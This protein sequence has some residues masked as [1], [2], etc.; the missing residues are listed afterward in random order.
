MG[1]KSVSTGRTTSWVLWAFAGMAFSGCSGAEF[2]AAAYGGP[3]FPSDEAISI[4]VQGGGTSTA[5]ADFSGDGTAG[6]RFGGY[7]DVGWPVDVGVGVDASYIGA[8]VDD[9]TDLDTAA[10][11]FLAMARVPF[12]FVSPYVAIGPSI[13]IATA[14]FENPLFDARD[15][16][17]AAA[18]DFRIGVE[19]KRFRRG[20]YSIGL[21]S[22]Y[23]LTNALPEFEIPGGLSIEV[24]SLT[25]HIL[26]GF[27]VGFGGG[28]RPPAAE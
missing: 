10:I 6:G 19:S 27:V 24:E 16:T 9:T 17:A 21:F 18:L 8:E 2:F 14:S 4:D 3:N 23:R 26:F 5:Q 12:E 20:M 7:W 25:H 22:E 28:E 13:H 1:R 11:S 15:T